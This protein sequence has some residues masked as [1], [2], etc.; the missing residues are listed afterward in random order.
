MGDGKGYPPPPSRL[1]SLE[2]RR[3]LPSVIWGGAPAENDFGAFW[4]E[5]ARTALVAILV[6]NFAFLLR[7]C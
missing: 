1:R 2:E 5:G 6:A 3:E 7:K 4:G